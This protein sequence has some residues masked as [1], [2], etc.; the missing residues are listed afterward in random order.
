M[1]LRF[2]ET[3][4]LSLGFLYIAPAV[5]TP[6]EAPVSTTAAGLHMI[7]SSDDSI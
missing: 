7:A 1:T 2:V 5:V 3:P 6:I 4:G